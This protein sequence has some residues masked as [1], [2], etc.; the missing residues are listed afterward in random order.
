MT[1]R[2]LATITYLMVFQAMLVGG[3]QVSVNFSSRNTTHAVGPGESIHFIDEEEHRQLVEW[4]ASEG[5]FWVAP[6]AEIATW[7]QAK[8]NR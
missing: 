1:R 3:Q 2:I 6:V 8:T 4:L 5:D 7:L